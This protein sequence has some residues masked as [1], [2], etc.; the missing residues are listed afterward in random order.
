MT[1]KAG[2]ESTHTVTKKAGDE[3][4]HT[5]A[6]KTGDESTLTVTKK[7]GDESI[8]TCNYPL[9]DRKTCLKKILMPFFKSAR[10]VLHVF[11]N[12]YYCYMP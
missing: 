5:V 1:K 2:D 11:V 3:S 9:I 6:K 8:Y 4:T 10:V 12:V 7:T